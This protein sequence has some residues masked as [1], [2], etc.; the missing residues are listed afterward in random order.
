MAESNVSLDSAMFVLCL[1]GIIGC[2]R[3][4]RGILLQVSPANRQWEQGA[5][6]RNVA[7]WAP[8]PI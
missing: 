7:R 2:R 6:R 3:N 1:Q 8:L 4:P 5:Q